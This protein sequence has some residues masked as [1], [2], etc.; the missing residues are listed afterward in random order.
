MKASY[1]SGPQFLLDN[2]WFPHNTTINILDIIRRRL[3]MTCRI[4]T[5]G[6]VTMV[7]CSV[8]IGNVQVC[9]TH[10]SIINIIQSLERLV[11]DGAEEIETGFDFDLRV[12]CFD[13]CGDDGEVV[14]FCA[15]IV[16]RGDFCDIDI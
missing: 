4:V 16:C 2:K 6:N 10:E 8:F 13:Y 1:L 7:F 5:L 9:D 15:D 11:E 12:V 14:V 3:K